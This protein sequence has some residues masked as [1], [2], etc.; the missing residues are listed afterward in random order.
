VEETSKKLRKRGHILESSIHR[1]FI[2]GHKVDYFKNRVAFDLE[3]NSKD[4]TFDRDFFAFRAFYECHLIDAAVI[5]TRSVE[6]N[7]VFEKLGVNLDDEGNPRISNRGK[8]RKI[9]D[10]YRA[11]T[12]W[13]GKLLYRVE[14]GRLGGCPLLAMTIKPELISDWSKDGK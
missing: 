1:N 8:P 14:A 4:Q 5:L 2:A 9:V 7:E 10:K 6:L 13:I 3:W 12:T 11:S